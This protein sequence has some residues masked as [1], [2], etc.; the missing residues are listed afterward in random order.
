M[1]QEIVIGAPIITAARFLAEGAHSEQKYGAQPYV[2]H[3]QEVVK[4]MDKILTLPSMAFYSYTVALAG[5][6]LHDSLE[7][8]RITHAEIAN[9]CGLRV[10][11][12]VHSVTDAPGANRHER[13]V[14]TYPKIRDGGPL[15]VALKLA[16]RISNVLKG[17]R[18]RDEAMQRMYAKEHKDFAGALYRYSDGLDSVWV[19]LDGY[20]KQGRK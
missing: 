3:L 16:D 15:P 20:I 1:S 10:A 7:D 11:T 2:A 13:K 9:V 6:W 18:T 19:E 17:L 12:L 14:A 4:R 5:A 8:T